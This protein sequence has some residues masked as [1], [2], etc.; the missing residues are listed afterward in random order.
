ML[1]KIILLSFFIFDVFLYPVRSFKNVD[2]LAF[3]SSFQAKLTDGSEK[4]IFYNDELHIQEDEIKNMSLDQVQKMLG[5]EIFAAQKDRY[6]NIKNTFNYILKRVLPAVFF[7]VAMPLIYYFVPYE[8]VLGLRYVPMLIIFCSIIFC[9]GKLI[10][11]MSKAAKE[12]GYWSREILKEN[13]LR[14]ALFFVFALC[15]IVSLLFSYVPQHYCLMLFTYSMVFFILL[16][17]FKFFINI[18]FIKKIEKISK[19]N[20]DNYYI[21]TNNYIQGDGLTTQLKNLFRYKSDSDILGAHWLKSVLYQQMKQ[22]NIVFNDNNYNR[23]VQKYTNALMD[24]SHMWKKLAAN[25]EG[26]KELNKENSLLYK[27]NEFLYV[28]DQVDKCCK[29]LLREA[30]KG[31]NF[32]IETRDILN[33]QIKSTTMFNRGNA[34]LNSAYELMKKR[35]CSNIRRKL[36]HEYYFQRSKLIKQ[37]GNYDRSMDNKYFFHHDNLS[38][39]PSASILSMKVP[40]FVRREM[41]TK[42]QN[43]DKNTK[44]TIHTS[45]A[46]PPGNISSMYL[47]DILSPQERVDLFREAYTF[48]KEKLEFSRMEE[49][50]FLKD[51]EQQKAFFGQTW[52][53]ILDRPRRNAL[54][55]YFAYVNSLAREADRG[56]NKDLLYIAANNLSD[57]EYHDIA[58]FLN[59]LNRAKRVSEWVQAFFENKV[60][61]LSDRNPNDFSVGDIK[62]LEIVSTSLLSPDKFRKDQ[63]EHRRDN[64]N[65]IFERENEILESLNG[66]KVPIKYDGKI[67]EVDLSV[68]QTIWPVNMLRTGL[69]S[70]ISGVWNRLFKVNKKGIDA[71]WKRLND[72][73]EKISEDDIFKR[74]ELMSLENYLRDYWK[75]KTYKKHAHDPYIM[76]KMVLLVGHF[77]DLELSVRCKS[78]KDRSGQLWSEM[79]FEFV[80]ADNNPNTSPYRQAYNNVLDED[81][82]AL[83]YKLNMYSGN[84]FNQYSNTGI[85]GSKLHNG[86]PELENRYPKVFYPNILGFS[87]LVKLSLVAGMDSARWINIDKKEKVAF[88]DYLE[89]GDKKKLQERLRQLDFFEKL[90]TVK[91]THSENVGN[92]E[93]PEIFVVKREGLRGAA[94]LDNEILV[95]QSTMDVL[96]EACREYKDSLAEKGALYWLLYSLID[97]ELGH[98]E[99]EHTV[100]KDHRSEQE[101][102]GEKSE[103]KEE[104]HVVTQCMKRQ[105]ENKDIQKCIRA[106]MEKFSERLVGLHQNNRYRKAF[107]GL[108]NNFDKNGFDETHVEQL[109]LQA[110]A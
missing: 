96:E 85:A 92:R 9:A 51:E 72:A 28:V 36:F 93:C 24:R 75:K 82:K 25:G 3:Q 64:E 13:F 62:K 8:V 86:D 11:S 74:N 98:W 77:L 58:E 45:S 81:L 43:S 108:I 40:N 55:N 46:L 47:R 69:L 109:L 83:L 1:L 70:K 66:K 99:Y 105:M 79:C 41:T 71:L 97:H 29:D 18:Y 30:K 73:K 87:K 59:I 84:F 33:Y 95:S 17:S 5:K 56:G 101:G 76:P 103:I 23:I 78:G 15:M 19:F 104:A 94:Y 35:L 100:L 44:M 38:Q 54:V 106:C 88:E 37:L 49:L 2:V 42:G 89:S 39:V 10:Q 102:F 90:E 60:R 50:N 6:E 57:S 61:K 53:S 32:K 31:V 80:R 4:S 110:Q 91:E 16:V 67:Y 7:V 34:Q 20:F 27:T 107:N 65:D 22:Y 12:E 21:Y 68:Y 48:L 26:F 63:C 14:I 52:D